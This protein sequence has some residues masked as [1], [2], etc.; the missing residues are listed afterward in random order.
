[1]AKPS[2][3]VGSSTEGI[4]VA[5]AVQVE[6][7]DV[8]EVTLWNQGFFGLSQGTIETLAN[9]VERFDF[10][11]LV[12]TPDDMVTHHG[13]P[14]MS[15]RDNVLFELG[16][17]MGRLGRARTYLIADP[18]AVRLPTDLAVFSVGGY[19]STRADGNLVAALGPAMYLIRN[20]IRDLGPVPDRGIEQF[21]RATDQVVDIS[22]TM[23]RLIHLLARSRAVELK[24]ISEQFGGLIRQDT[25]QEMLADLNDLQQSTAGATTDRP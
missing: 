5:R 20:A 10:A 4:E 1:M 7:H 22:S 18:R 12:A 17:F 9:S 2:L 8:A 19:D 3:F 13:E 21:A 25:L 11:V 6:L 24:I 16:L 15:A 14:V 23:E